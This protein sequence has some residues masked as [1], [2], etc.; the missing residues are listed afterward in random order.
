MNL[1]VSHLLSS[2]IDTNT[3]LQVLEKNRSYAHSNYRCLSCWQERTLP[4]I[5][6]AVRSGPQVL[7]LINDCY[8]VWSTSPVVLTNRFTKLSKGNRRTKYNTAE[9]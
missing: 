7:S 3:A 9:S 4:G 1:L 6:C 8:I 2:D 5:N